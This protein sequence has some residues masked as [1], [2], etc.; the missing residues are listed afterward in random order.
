MR[1]TQPLLKRDAEVAAHRH[2]H[3]VL[4]GCMLPI[5]AFEDLHQLS[6]PLGLPSTDRN[7][8]NNYEENL[9]LS[10]DVPH[11]AGFLAWRPL[12]APMAP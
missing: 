1:L 5:S 12:W 7:D 11:N 8:D 9:C 3:W 10:V 6:K 4:K 2:T